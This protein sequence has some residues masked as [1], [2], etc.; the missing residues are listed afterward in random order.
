MMYN[1]I[2]LSVY[3]VRALDIVQTVHAYLR[4]VFLTT[5]DDMV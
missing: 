1:T 4:T 5:V 3:D 2:S